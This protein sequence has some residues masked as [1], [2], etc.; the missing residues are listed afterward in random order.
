M[1]LRPEADGPDLSGVYRRFLPGGP[2]FLEFRYDVVRA[3]LLDGKTG[4]RLNAFLSVLVDRISGL[5]ILLMVACIGVAVYPRPLPALV[6]GSVWG[7][8]TGAIVGLVLLPGLTRWLGDTRFERLRQLSEGM[9][10]YLGHPRLMLGTAA[11]SV[12]V[13][14]ANVALV[15]F[16]GLAI[17]VPVPAVYYLILVPLV[18]LLTLLPV[19]LNGMGIREWT[20]ALFLAQ[21][22][23][24]ESAALCLA[25]LWFLVLTVVSL[26]G[27]L[28][29]LFAGQWA[30]VRFPRTEGQLD[31]GSIGGDSHQGRTRQSKAAA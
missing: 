10:F 8:A 19:S 22:G 4:R 29:Y 14:L 1:L 31:H 13:Q 27:G 23:V 26:T 20:T 25:L 16:L 7:M 17:G 18:S 28:V 24:G 5:M 6:I 21:L 9:Q 11:L 12:V 3:W 15:W 2:A 30:N